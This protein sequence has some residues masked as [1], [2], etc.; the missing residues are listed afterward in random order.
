MTPY[1]KA[2]QPVTARQTSSRPLFD[3]SACVLGDVVVLLLW[4]PSAT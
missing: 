3:P 2:P 1:S 4:S